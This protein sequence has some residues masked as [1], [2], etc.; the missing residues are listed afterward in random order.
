V[1]PLPDYVREKRWADEITPAILVGDAVY[2]ALKSGQSFFAIHAPNSKARADA[3]RRLWGSGQVSVAGAD[4]YFTGAESELAR[5]VKR[6][7][8]QVTH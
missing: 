2:L 4:H 5:H 8:D 7:L 6:F 3:I 1:A